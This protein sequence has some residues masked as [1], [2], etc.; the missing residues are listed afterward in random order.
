M[1]FWSVSNVNSTMKRL[2]R[3]AE[4]L[5]WTAFFAFAV[6]VLGLRFWLLPNIE[7]YRDDI[8]AAVTRTIGRPVKI[9][10]IEA[11]WL[12]LR[13]QVSFADVRIYDA[14]GREALVLP[15]V[16]NVLSWKS[17]IRG[18]LR[19]E[20]LVIE[21]PRLAARRDAA[22]ALYIAGIKLSDAKGDGAMLDWALRQDEIVVRNAEIEWQD[23]KRGAPPLALSAL[24][25]RL[26]NSG[27]AHSLGVSARPPPAL[28]SGLELRAELTG[29]SAAD[30]A[31]WSGR[32]YAELGYTDLAGWRPWVDY[33][34]EMQAGQGALRLWASLE[35]G[36]FVQAT[37]DVELS[38]IAARL[39]KDLPLLELARISGRIQALRRDEGFEVAGKK[40]AVATLRGPAMGP[41]DIR[42]EWH[43]EGKA[44][45]QG[46]LSATLVE[47]E[48]LAQL[49]EALP[50]PEPIRKRLAELAPRGRLLDAKLQWS[51]KLA[52]PAK[53]GA[54][55]KFSEVAMNARDSFPGVAGL[56]GSIEA[57]EANGRVQL[58]SRK[59]E[60]EL[61]RV[62]PERVALDL[63]EGQID[64]ERKGERALDVKLASLS[65][66]NADLEGKATGRYSNSG[67]GP[68]TIDLEAN[69]KRAD[70]S[71]VARYLPGPAILG[72]PTRD[73]LAAA[74]LAGRGSDVALKLKGD[75]R[76]FPFLDPAKGQFQV[77]A[78]V[79]K[80]VLE[81]VP[82]WPRIT[83]IDAELLFERDRMQI[84]ARSAS[85]LGA[86]LANVRVSI[87]S[88]LAP[89]RHLLV[90]G[91]A[92]GPTSE[93]LKFIESSPV[94]R[95]IG[96]CTDGMIAEGRGKLALKLDLPLGDLAST[97]V[98]G[99]FGFAANTV[100]IPH[101]NLP[102]IEAAGGRV[103]F[104]QSSLA[105]RDLKGRVFDGPVT[106]SGGTRPG[107]VLEIVARG[108]AQVAA[109]Q[110]VLDHPWRRYLS[111]AA[112]YSA[113]VQLREGR[114]RIIVE[115]SLRG[116]SSALP[117][118]LAKSAA[119]PLPLRVEIHPADATGRERIFATLGSLAALDLQ[120][121]RDG[122]AMALQRA[123]LLLAPS[124]RRA[125]LPER[126]GLLIYGTLPALDVDRWLPFSAAGEH[127]DTS[128]FAVA[129][130][131]K[132]GTL[133]AYGKRIHDLAL[134]ADLADGGW[135]AAVQSEEIAGD[136]S[137]RSDGGGK[138][139]VRLTR[140]R[141]PDDYPGVKPQDASRTK[142]WPSLD[143]IAERF[144]YKG[145][146]LGRIELAAQREGAD[147]RIDKIALANAEASVSGKGVWRT[148]DAPQTSVTLDLDARDAG[149][150]LA[151]AGYP[152]LVR[153]GKAKMHAALTWAGEPQAIDYPSLSGS[154]QLQAEDGQFL[155]I[156]PGIGKLISLMSL[157]ALPKR[158]ALD[159]RDVFSKGFQFDRI[160]AAGDIERGMM[161][162]KDFKMRGS[163]AEVDMEGE[164]DLAKE[165]QSL[166]VR[167]I[168]SLG[169]PASAALVFLNPLLIFPA[170]IA[171]KI[172][173]DPLGH[174]FAFNYSVT[175]T[176]ADPKVAKRAVE[177]RA[178]EHPATPAN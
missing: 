11:G 130:D 152:G 37:A 28:G 155:E 135:T 160:A 102:P 137:F 92:D 118:P 68:G 15:S 158:L 77:A 8:V 6:L 95:M 115:S 43:P 164:V 119:D 70:G 172:L 60:L 34:V 19:L 21:G 36:R 136:A 104:T 29:S 84:V 125:R 91:Q 16:D 40:L 178:V 167:V 177:A 1:D 123:A 114:A 58:A 142:D 74:I 88:L 12:G 171:Q 86:K 22:G 51:G 52:Q 121:R 20:S 174:I 133:D 63:L 100:T 145:K 50:F 57:T 65:F 4:I 78:R 30:L 26:R 146:E 42:L 128:K 85:V 27:S 122:D 75:L 49:A 168:P 93:F 154:L 143:L 64:W 45:E 112:P 127:A 3:A 55:A 131:L 35:K 132:I 97:K 169:D 175:G 153:G 73:W 87:P 147:W 89:L 134:R 103:S 59:A 151:R 106:V 10:A 141:V 2:W 31:A 148:G 108:D 101:G 107:G 23:E 72:Q 9:G 98:E 18:T 173:K 156:E 165:T 90:E 53:F 109:L 99:E 166:R 67:E 138:L 32:V 94:Q 96:G 124:G 144:V 116:V 159:F 66:G 82:G 14:E 126:P 62:L 44:A 39:D 81:Y 150:A 13:P 38:G 71:R 117:A 162:L 61:P 140:L 5:A 56:S 120:R 157:Q 139:V 149:G 7:R 17:L 33:P 161:T 25:L 80:G 47:L 24:D 76:D 83:D 110:P 170:A 176:W 54:T 105:L 41:A 46:A 129:L 48:P 69:L 113:T 163:A 79:E 111:G